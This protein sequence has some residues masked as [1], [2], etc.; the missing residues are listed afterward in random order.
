MRDR[1]FGIETEYAVIYHPAKAETARPTNLS[2]YPR[3]ESALRQRIR[4]LPRALSLLRTKEGRFLENGGSFHYEATPENYEHGLIEMASPECRDP[5]ALIHYERAKDELIEELA[6]EVNQELRLAGHAGEVRIGKN[7][8]DSQA[9]TFGSHESYW[10]EDPLPILARLAFLPIWALLWALSLP[11]L[12]WLIVAPLAVLVVTLVA[13]VLLLG[14]GAVISIARPSAARRMLRWVES[15]VGRIESRPGGLV[16]RM[17]RLAAPL[18]P[19]L[20]LH[21]MLYNRFHFRAFRQNLTAFLVTR[22]AYCGAGAVAFD[23]G[24][25]LRLAQRPPFVR[26]LARIFPFGEERPIFELRDLFFRPWSALGTR[27]RL[28][29]LI[30][31]ANLSEWAQV[32]RVGATALVLEAIESGRVGD[33]PV[34]SD[35][36]EALE[37]VNRDPT[38]RCELQL[39]SGERISTLEIQRRY[40]RGVREVLAEEPGPIRLWKARVL[41]MWEEGLDLLEENP[42]AL[43]DRIDWIAK[44]RVLDGEV[45]DAADREALRQRGAEVLRGEAARAPGDR[46]LRELAYSLWRADLRYHELGPRGG[47]RRLE[48]SGQMRRLS[49]PDRVREARTEPPTDTRAWAR[50][51][52]IKWAHAHTRSGGVAWHRVRLGKFDWR[53]FTDPL[54]PQR[55]DEDG[56]DVPGPRGLG[57]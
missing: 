27:R 35:P 38:F 48:E 20:A 19:L 9:H 42:D 26:T 18:F 40:L 17:N 44:R 8:V 1:V 10:V 15:T 24:P 50:G 45:P 53:W 39:V 28:H 32:L 23:G 34:L 46:R 3:F 22:T 47:Y 56:P 55:S 33:W 52:A 14:T 21:S 30:G 25:L 36:L 54:D 4:T 57:S 51:Q 37:Q 5:F 6:E 11:V 2:L 49:V 29:L 12:A 43:A 7:N 31:D 16:R 41:Q 13:G